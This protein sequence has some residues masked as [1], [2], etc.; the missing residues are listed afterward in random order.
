[1]I[2]GGKDHRCHRD[3]GGI[4]YH[5]D[6]KDHRERTKNQKY[7]VLQKSVGILNFACNF[8]TIC[9]ILKNEISIC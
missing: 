9:A 3:H 6:P 1:M 2:I 4:K 8:D 7:R 5:R